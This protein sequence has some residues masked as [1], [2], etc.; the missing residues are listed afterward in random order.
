[1]KKFQQILLN[2]IPVLLMIGLIPAVLND[3]WLTAVYALIILVA[4][5]VKKDKNDILIFIFGFFIMIVSEYL[6]VSTGVE[7]FQRN[8]LFDL[9]PLW[10]PFLWGYG[11]IV[12]RRV[13][14]ILDAS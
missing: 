3:Y 6:F 5:I 7:T 9:M 8:S 14:K 1:M 2:I 4:L 10:L 12:I 13:T 11:F